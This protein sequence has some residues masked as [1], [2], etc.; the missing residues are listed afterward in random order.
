MEKNMKVMKSIKWGV[1]VFLLASAMSGNAW[2]DRGYRHG[3]HRGGYTQFGVVIGPGWGPWYYPPA[4]YYPPSP[5]I[6]IE[7]APQVYIEQYA[8]P[9]APEVQGSQPNY[10]Y[11]CNASKAYYPYVNECPRG[12]Q[13]VLPQ[14]PNPQ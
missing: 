6:V 10:W 9:P 8:P 7:R 5:P 3:N 14:P 2:A 4:Y 13:R 11:Y 12:W 1:V